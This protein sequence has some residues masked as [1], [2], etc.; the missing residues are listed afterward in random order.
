MAIQRRIINIAILASGAGTNAKSIVNHFE[1]NDF[2][3]V[4]LLLS[5]KETSGIVD[6][7]G[8]RGLDYKIFTRAEFRD[9]DLFL[10]ILNEYKIDFI[11]LAGF[12]WLVPDYLVEAYENRI[13][14]IHPSLLPKYGGKGMYGLNVHQSVFE[15]KE[16]YSGLTI[17]L[18]NK[19]YDE[20][21]VLFQHE[22][23]ISDCNSP[24]EIAAQI[25]KQE[26]DLY[27]KI[28]DEYILS[29]KET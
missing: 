21:E 4:N 25:L 26:H 14:N 1:S 3:E 9:K 23:D 17:H 20:G 6:I 2:I 12:L 11:I 22:E 28:I 5:N 10:D 13:L 19:K 7:A 24:E 16:K 29:F 8:D 27:P 18:V 15:N